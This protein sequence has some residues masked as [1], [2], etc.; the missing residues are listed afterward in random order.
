MD[1]VDGA[2]MMLNQVEGELRWL[3]L[4]LAALLTK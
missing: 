4:V 2:K 3:R 1:L